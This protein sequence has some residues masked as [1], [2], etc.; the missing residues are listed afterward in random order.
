MAEF[1]IAMSL[2]V[3]V[4]LASA[5]LMSSA[6][7]V[8]G[9]TRMRVIAANVATETLE[10]ARGLADNGNFNILIAL[11]GAGGQYGTPPTPTAQRV[12]NLTVYVSQTIQWENQ[13][14]TVSQCLA[15]TAQPFIL[16]VTANVTWANM[17]GAR[18][19]TS[20][21]TLAPPVGSFTTSTGSLAT[22]VE[23]SNGNP[24]GGI[25]VTATDPVNAANNQSF[26]TGPDGCAFFASVNPDSYNVTV[27]KLTWV[28]GQ[29][30]PSPPGNTAPSAS[31]TVVA[32]LINKTP[33]FYFDQSAMIMS[34]L[35]TTT[36]PATGMAMS[37]GNAQLAP[38]PMKT[39]GVGTLALGSLFPYPSGYHVFA[40][41]CTDADPLGTGSGVPF[42]SSASATVIATPPGGVVSG[43][44]PLYPLSVK[45]TDLGF[46][47]PATITATET[48]GPVPACARGITGTYGLTNASAAGLSL[49]GVTLGHLKLVATFLGQSTTTPIYVLMEPDGMHTL[50]ATGNN[51]SAGPVSGPIA[52]TIP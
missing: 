8:S 44:V 23:D 22:L 17:D 35:S 25:L 46:P 45:V 48:G 21:T 49:T 52:V 26:S 19:V 20:S 34:T 9:N 12:G 36:P 3:I 31:L 2:L 18:P 5:K 29:G 13:R 7:T 38:L 39:Y 50:D 4:I 11:P 15:N 27:S 37:V 14:G 51:P 41:V 32:G 24:E 28:D 10:K 47:V 30:N 43:T 1:I 33:T 6:I 42:Y 40:G 16:R